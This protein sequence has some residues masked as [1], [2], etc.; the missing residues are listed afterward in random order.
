[1]PVRDTDDNCTSS[2]HL[3]TSTTH[4]TWCRGGTA[5]TKMSSFHD[6]DHNRGRR[7]GYPENRVQ[8]RM[9]VKL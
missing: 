9:M 1:M 5:Q 6:D 2:F 7:P 4:L 3:Q 8:Q